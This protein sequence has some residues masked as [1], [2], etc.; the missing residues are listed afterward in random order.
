MASDRKKEEE[1]PEEADSKV[2]ESE[3]EHVPIKGKGKEIKDILPPKK[4]PKKEIKEEI[5]QPLKD[6]KKDGLKGDMK[7]LPKGKMPVGLKEDDE[8]ETIALQ[9]LQLSKPVRCNIC[10]GNIKPGTMAARCKCKKHYH[11][12]CAIR[13]G[14]CPRCGRKFKSSIRIKDITEEEEVE[15]WDSTELKKKEKKE[16]KEREGKA[17]FLKKIEQRLA[18]GDISEKTYLELREKYQE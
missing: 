13:V 9:M 14:E 6:K 11:E 16:K 4:K 1:I 10:L 12:S 18:D 17:E 8:I 2:V 3:V 15:A 5:A 7:K